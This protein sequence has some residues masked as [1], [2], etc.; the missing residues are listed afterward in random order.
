MDDCRC[1]KPYGFFN[2]R[3]KYISKTNYDNMVLDYEE[4]IKQLIE[5]CCTIR[6][7]K[8]LYSQTKIEDISI[9]IYDV[10]EFC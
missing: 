7:A 5:D 6:N 10:I 3:K 1:L 2:P 9:C 4:R 8:Y